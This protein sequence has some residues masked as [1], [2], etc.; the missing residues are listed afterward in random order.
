MNGKEKSQAIG[1][2]FAFIA[3]Y[4]KPKQQFILRR[5]YYCPGHSG[6]ST[7]LKVIVE[8]DVR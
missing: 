3:K 8:H 6:N 7:L 2:M 5:S 1:R 4:T